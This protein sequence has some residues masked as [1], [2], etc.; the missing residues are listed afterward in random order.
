MPDL[1]LAINRKIS[2]RKNDAFHFK[3]SV[4]HGRVYICSS[5]N[6]E[7]VH[8]YDNLRDVLGFKRNIIEGKSSGNISGME[9]VIFTDFPPGLS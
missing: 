9:R 1:P 5:I 6:N 8:L 2:S 4:E 3:F 7:L